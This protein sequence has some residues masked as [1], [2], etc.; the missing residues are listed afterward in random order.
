MSLVRNLATWLYG[1]D[2]RNTN[3]KEGFFP[4]LQENPL[5]YFRLCFLDVHKKSEAEICRWTSAQMQVRDR[6]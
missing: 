1:L 3:G 5:K 4:S 6:A 2:A